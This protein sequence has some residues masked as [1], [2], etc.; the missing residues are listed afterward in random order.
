LYQLVCFISSHDNFLSIDFKFTCATKSASEGINFPTSLFFPHEENKRIS[1]DNAKQI[2]RKG[3]I[4]KDL[5]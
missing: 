5:R 3:F 4:K 1:A 2:L